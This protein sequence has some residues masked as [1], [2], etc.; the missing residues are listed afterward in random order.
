[1]SYVNDVKHDT[2][3]FVNG[4]FNYTGFQFSSKFRYHAVSS[5]FDVVL[6]L[7]YRLASWCWCEWI[8]FFWMRFDNIFT[9]TT[10]LYPIW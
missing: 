1:M 5:F 10:G 4:P 9:K 6:S 8:F 7:D 2:N 3:L